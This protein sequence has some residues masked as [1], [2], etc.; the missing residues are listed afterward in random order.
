MLAHAATAHAE[1]ERERARFAQR[2][3]QVANTREK[4]NARASRD[5]RSTRR[6]AQAVMFAAEMFRARTAREKHETETA[7]HECS[8]RDTLTKLAK[9]RADNTRYRDDARSRATI[10]SASFGASRLSARLGRRC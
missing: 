3:Q 6:E 2:P 7:D 10:R 4:E 5:A 9:G 1:R 8:T